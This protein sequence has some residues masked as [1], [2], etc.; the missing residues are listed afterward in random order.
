[1]SLSSSID[2]STKTLCLIQSLHMA[3]MPERT[4]VVFSC[5]KEWPYSTSVRR[6]SLHSAVG[7]LTQ[8]EYGQAG[9]YPEWEQEAGSQIP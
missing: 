5:F 3:W 6:F 9:V 1:M 7:S 8:E 2:T 4:K